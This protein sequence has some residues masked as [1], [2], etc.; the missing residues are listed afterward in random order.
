MR[1]TYLVCYDVRD[2]KRLRRVFKTC[3]DYGDHLQY[4]LFEGDLS[5]REEVEMEAV[6]KVWREN[7]C[8]AT[9]N[10]LPNARGGRPGLSFRVAPEKNQPTLIGT[11]G[12][13]DWFARFAVVLEE[14][15]A[16]LLTLAAD[17]LKL[18]YAS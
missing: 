5:P 4:S 15:P 12:L 6:L 11:Y 18:Q 2:D 9:C 3:K 17:R 1:T 14:T 16:D 7:D 10:T 8:I 13:D